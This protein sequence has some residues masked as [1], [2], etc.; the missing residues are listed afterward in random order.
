MRLFKMSPYDKQNI[1]ALLKGEGDWFTA[2]LLR[3][4][5]KA[6]ISNRERLRLG[7]PEEVAAFE[8]WHKY[9]MPSLPHRLALTTELE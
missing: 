7:F 6:D 3:L 9:P 8:R 4:I 1:D 5:S 2:Q